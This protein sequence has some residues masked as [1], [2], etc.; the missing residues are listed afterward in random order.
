MTAFLHA[1]RI[2]LLDS[3][4][5]PICPATGVIIEDGDG[6][7]LYT[8]WHVVTGIN[9]LDLKVPHNAWPPSRR[10]IKYQTQAIETPNPAVVTFGGGVDRVVPLYRENDGTFIPLWQQE[11]NSIACP[12]LAHVGLKV[13]KFFDL[14]R[15]PIQ[16]EQA[17]EARISIPRSAISK[18]MIGPSGK[19]IVVGYPYGYSIRGARWP[20]PV[21][22]MRFVAAEMSDTLTMLLDAEAAPGMSGAPVFIESKHPLPGGNQWDLLGVYTGAVF[23]DAEHLQQL[24]PSE[25]RPPSNDRRAALGVVCSLHLAEAIGGLGKSS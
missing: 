2:W 19:V 14:V 25:G 1:V 17:E 5:R 11:R 8:C 16:I 6:V 4:D 3:K 20:H 15:I 22:I 12:D 18:N 21:H 23:A 13:P 10:K 24:Q 9:F 7:F